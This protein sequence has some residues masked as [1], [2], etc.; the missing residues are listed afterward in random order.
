MF[1]INKIP[2]GT[3]FLAFTM[4]IAYFLLAANTPYIT[5]NNID[6]Y[7]LNLVHPYSI[8][9]HLFIHVGVYHIIGNLLPLILFG[10]VLESALLTLDVWF[11]F[12]ISGT[13][14]SLLFALTN[15]G[16][17]LIGASAG[18]SGMLSSVMLVKPKS[19]LALLIATPLLIS[20]VFFPA[21][22]FAGKFYEENLVQKQVVQ[23]QQL[24]QAVQTNQSEQV[25]AQLNQTLQTTEQQI[26]ITTEGKERESSTPTDFMVHVYGAVIG[27]FYVYFLKRKS[28]KAAEQDFVSIGEF[29]FQKADTISKMLRKRK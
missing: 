25:V 9:T 2:Y 28:L 7:A 4:L 26:T 27:A 12:L 11:I 17:P 23:Q 19:A 1:G 14:A 29:I 22:D 5:E 10:L 21:A 20:F 15:P 3:L 18:I 24:V 6:E 16:I 8:L 13:L